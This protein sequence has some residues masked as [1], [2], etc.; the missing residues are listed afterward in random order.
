MV[1]MNSE[2]FEQDVTKVALKRHR[3]QIFC[4]T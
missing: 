4:K 3:S 1:E 2:F